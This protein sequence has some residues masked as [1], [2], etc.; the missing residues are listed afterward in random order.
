[1][2]SESMKP[3]AV[4]SLGQKCAIYLLLPSSLCD[5]GGG[6]RSHGSEPRGEAPGCGMSTPARLR[7][8]STLVDISRDSHC[9]NTPASALR[10]RGDGS[11]RGDGIA[12]S[13][14]GGGSPGIRLLSVRLSLL[15]RPLVSDASICEPACTGSAVLNSSAGLGGSGGTL[16][17]RAAH[18][19]SSYVALKSQQIQPIKQTCACRECLGP[20]KAEANHER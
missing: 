18:I 17:R 3:I 8:D 12:G 1:M 2:T 11:P 15:P 20:E 10:P 13:G 16:C 7:N 19:V 9:N 5:R 14:R 4:E 6:A